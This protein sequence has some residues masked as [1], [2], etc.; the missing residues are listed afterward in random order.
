[1]TIKKTVVARGLPRIHPGLEQ[2]L[3][4]A[5]DAERKGRSVRTYDG[6]QRVTRPS[7]DASTEERAWQ[8]RTIGL[9]DPAYK[10]TGDGLLPLAEQPA[11]RPGQ[12]LDLIWDDLAEAEKVRAGATERFRL[13]MESVLRR[14][15]KEFKAPHRLG[16]RL[17]ARNLKR[18]AENISA[19]VATFADILAP[20]SYS[21]LLRFVDETR[22]VFDTAMRNQTVQGIDAVFSYELIR[23]LAKK[24]VYQELV[25]RR[26]GMGDRGIR[27]I[28]AN[29]Q[30][31]ESLYQ[32]LV[33][34]GY[35]TVRHRLLMRIIH[36]HQDLGHT[37]YAA[38][39]SFRGGRLHRAYGARIFVD[40]TNRLRPLLTPQEL[41]L[42]RGAVATHSSEELPYNQEIV[43]AL[44]RVADHL[45]P[46]AP[47]RV[48]KHL[49]QVPGV[50]DYLDDMLVRARAGDGPRYAAVRSSLRRFLAETTELPETLRD[51]II[52]DFRPI[53]RGADFIDLREHAGEV[54]GISIEPTAY[55]GGGRVVAQVTYD[56]FT[57]K[58]QGLFD[59]QQDQL[60]RLARTTRVNLETEG[61]N[62]RFMLPGSGALEMLFVGAP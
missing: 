30:I 10:S 19:E 11:F 15:G 13:E 58:Y 28:L 1:V 57:A 41:E 37:A 54:T 16:G 44:V 21:L 17:D 59:H 23:D 22:A 8:A 18:A 40:E 25:S 60:T 9:V 24:L 45:A 27:R 20:D 61:D 26:R 39:V 14:A 31:G 7:I 29:I 35:A 5:E 36:V 49:E 43:L 3:R 56:P 53:D 46:F 2:K 38:R 48:Y 52:A 34:A 62:V 47:Y 6:A 12:D 4:E 33:P 51:D 55:T 32:Q 50:T 42:V